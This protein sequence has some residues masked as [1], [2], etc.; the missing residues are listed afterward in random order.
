MK[1][2]S[3]LFFT[4]LLLF[5]LTIS[6]H[7]N[8]SDHNLYTLTGKLPIDGFDGRFVYLYQIGYDSVDYVL[9]DSARIFEDSFSFTGEIPERLTAY[10]LFIGKEDVNRIVHPPLL[11]VPEK[12]NIEMIL[13]KEYTPVV[14]GTE[15]ND[16]LYTFLSVLN[17]L[18]TRFKMASD[19]LRGNEKLKAQDFEKG[20]K[21]SALHFREKVFPYLEEIANTPL[22]DELYHMTFMY[23]NNNDRKLI[24][25]TTTEAYKKRIADRIMKR[26]NEG[27]AK[28][29]KPFLD[30]NCFDEK[31]AV[32]RLSDYIPKN[33]TT[34]LVFWA[35]WCVPCVREIPELKNLYNKYKNKGFSIV[36]VSIDVDVQ[37]WKRAT[38]KYNMPWVQLLTQKGKNRVVRVYGFSS[39]PQTVLINKDGLIIDKNIRGSEI[40]IKLKELS[41]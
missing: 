27:N 3:C 28:I 1:K 22:V 25:E 6:C 38:D 13:D 16:K 41:Y 11:F 10:H 30:I 40:E 4:S 18:N 8:K 29:G 37:D 9:L 2:K 7:E 17:D 32:V 20:L 12:G 36:S 21:N 19:S 26:K 23:W 31:G 24:Y 35:S 34:L 39:I 5:V 14:S 33:N 15:Q